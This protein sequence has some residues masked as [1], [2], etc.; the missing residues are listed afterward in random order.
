[1]APPHPY[2]RQPGRPG[3]GPVFWAL[4]YYNRPR[5][6]FSDSVVRPTESSRVQESLLEQGEAQEAAV[7]GTTLL[8]RPAGAETISSQDVVGEPEGEHRIL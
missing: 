1:M 4:L 3:L 5:L 8:Q 7:G 2:S 6:S